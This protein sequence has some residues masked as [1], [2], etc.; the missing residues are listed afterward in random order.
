M[1]V[2]WENGRTSVQDC[3]VAVRQWGVKDALD[4]LSLT[5]PPSVPALHFA[6]H[7]RLQEACVQACY[8]K[9][10][11]AFALLKFSESSP[12]ST[13]FNICWSYQPLLVF[14]IPL[15]ILPKCAVSV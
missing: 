4:S 13:P 10:H 9:F 6:T 8:W 5:V 3:L 7:I 15:C 14:P 11:L 2:P 1:K 12:L